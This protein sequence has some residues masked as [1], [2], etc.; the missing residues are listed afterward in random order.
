GRLVAWMFRTKSTYF[1]VA[2]WSLWII[3]LL[4][5]GSLYLDKIAPRV[6]G[7]VTQKNEFIELEREGGWTNHFQVAFQ[8]PYGGET[9]SVQLN[10]SAADYDR[11]QKGGT[12]KLEIA[13]IYRTVALVR[14]A[15]INTWGWL[16]TPLRWIALIAAVALLL[17]WMHFIKSRIAWIFI[18]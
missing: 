10:L 18:I 7:D 17:W 1:H 4:V 3:T 9:G 13:P 5:G 2:W 14:L 6:S 15:T 11:L 16:V 8:Y 12:A